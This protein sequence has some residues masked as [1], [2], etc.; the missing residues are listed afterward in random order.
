MTHIHQGQACVQRPLRFMVLDVSGDINIT[1][2]RNHAL[3]QACA[4]PGAQSH[5]ADRLFGVPNDPD[6]LASKVLRRTSYKIFQ[7]HLSR[8]KPDSSH[9]A[10]AGLSEKKLIRL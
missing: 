8:Q 5:T 1:L 3:D 7:R 9:P 2:G 10:V 4:A 6:S